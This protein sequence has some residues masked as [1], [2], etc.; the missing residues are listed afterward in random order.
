MKEKIKIS[1]AMIS[2]NGE[3]KIDKTLKAVYDWADE[4]VIVDSHSSDKTVEIA[5]KY[6]A[7]VFDEDWKGEGLQYSSVVEKCK[8]EWVLL[9]DQDE[10]LTEKLKTEIDKVINGNN[11]F[12]VYKI[13]LINNCFDKFI[14]HGEKWVKT[15]LFKKELA[16]FNDDIVHV[17]IDVKEKSGILKEYI[18]HYTYKDI[19]EYAYKMNL[20]STGG[21]E[22]R[23]K[24]GK[25]VGITKLFFSPIFKF[26]RQYFFQLGILDGFEGFLL[27][28]LSSG[29]TFLVYSKLRELY[30]NEKK[31]L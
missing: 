6:K 14:W 3:D 9:I 30:K 12:N 17:S 10:V 13:R 18:E 29:Y 28:V 26:I 15:I 22:D 7:K 25:K 27:A 24:R 8:G 4:I 21:A 11:K 2:F 20:Y 1:I 23:Y 19:A 31:K 5:K 16:K